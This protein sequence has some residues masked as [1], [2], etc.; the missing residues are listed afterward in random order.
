MSTCNAIYTLEEIESELLLWKK[1]LRA[2]ATGKSYTIDGS[3]LTRQDLDQ[4]RTHISWLMAEK[5]KL[6]RRSSAV[7]VRPRFRR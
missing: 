4:I 2:C 7:F 6:E 5:A 3:T 1:A